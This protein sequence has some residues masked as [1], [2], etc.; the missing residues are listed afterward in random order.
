MIIT[1]TPF[2]ISFVGGGSDLEAFSM[3]HTGAVLST[4][5]DKYMYL[6]SHNFFNSDKVRLKYAKTE[7]VS[8]IAAIE[9]PIVREVLQQFH[10]EGA[11]E[12]SSNADVPAGTGLGSSSAFTVGLLHNMYARTSEFVTKQ[13]LAEEACEIEINRLGEPIGKQDQYAAAF[14]GL[15]IITFA[16]TG[17]VTVEPIHL[18]RETYRRLR[19][20]L[21]LLY[22][23]SE[24]ATADILNDQRRNM[25]DEEK[26]ARLCEMVKFVWRAR[27]A[28]YRDDIEGFGKLLHEN[29][30]LKRELASNIANEQ[31]DTLYRTALNAGAFGGK[32]L[33]AGGGGF[34]LLCCPPGRRDALCSAMG[35][36]RELGFKF[37]NEGSKVIYAGGE[38]D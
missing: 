12:I 26:V 35:G 20:S 7:T 11:L 4:T 30:V 16:T 3:Q 34:L 19:K 27:D 31:I 24:R 15:N 38:Y 1:K 37:E 22:L 5:I 25:A 29:W 8:D 6:S 14:G 18:K 36:L 13:R 32:V 21:V 10:V 33:G 2:R 17:E 28:L 23:G 9:H